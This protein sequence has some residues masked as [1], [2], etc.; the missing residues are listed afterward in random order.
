MLH[1]LGSRNGLTEAEVRFICFQL[2]AKNKTVI[3]VCILQ[4][5][6]LEFDFFFNWSQ[7][8]KFKKNFLYFK[9]VLFH[10]LTKICKLCAV[11]ICIVRVA[12]SNRLTH[13]IE[14]LSCGC[15]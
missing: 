13:F 11:L 15:R 12:Y 6:E 9:H 4:K 7:K 3:G 1:D 8:Y 14:L 2:S 10:N 5:K